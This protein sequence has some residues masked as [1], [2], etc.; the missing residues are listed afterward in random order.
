MKQG[1]L[2]R[3]S[4]F[5]TALG[6]AVL[7]TACTKT[8][9][10]EEEVLLNNGHSIVITREAEFKY[11]ISQDRLFSPYW[12]FQAESLSFQW[13]GTAYKFRN[14][15]SEA[16]LISIAP[17]I[18]AIDTLGIPNIF[19]YADS[20]WVHHKW[21]GCANTP[22]VKLVP[23]KRTWVVDPSRESWIFDLTINLNSDT[24][25]SE[26]KAKV[27]WNEKMEKYEKWA[28]TSRKLNPAFVVDSCIKGAL[29]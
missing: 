27:T 13:L 1:G 8:V 5:A 15:P 21:Q 23:S 9:K 28:T 6:I 7:L 29:K 18:L 17:L 22:I 11:D 24:D 25:Y 12:Q 26:S 10:W 19:G 16:D 20:N 2:S 4:S 3:R 14:A